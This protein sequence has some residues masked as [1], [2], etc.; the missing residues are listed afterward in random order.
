MVV[1]NVTQKELAIKVVYYGPPLSGKTTNLQKVYSFIRPQYRGKLMELD[2]KDDRTIFFDLLP[3]SFRTKKDYRINL[4]LF[5]VPGQVIHNATRRQ[6]LQQ[7]DG[8]VFVADAQKDRIRLNNS[9]WENMLENLESNGIDYH[10]VPV[11][12]QFN[13]IDLPDRLEDSK[14]EQFM[15]NSDRPVIKAS[16]INGEGVLETLR[17]LLVILWNN[18]DVRFR[19]VEKTGLST[20]EFIEAIFSF[21]KNEEPELR[22]TTEIKIEDRL[23][24]ELFHFDDTLLYELQESFTE[25]F[26]LPLSFYSYTNK[27]L[28]TRVPERIS[29]HK[30]RIAKLHGE[31]IR[32]KR[33]EQ[34]VLKEKKLVFLPLKGN[35]ATCISGVLFQ[36]EPIMK[37]VIGPYSLIDQKVP[38]PHYDEKRVKK[39]ANCISTVAT[40]LIYADY[41]VKVMTEQHVKTLKETF[42]E[43]KKKH[44]ELE[45]A[46]SKLKEVDRLKT[47]F[48][49]KVSHEL[50]TPLTSIKGYL[51]FIREDLKDASDDVKKY[52]DIVENK[53]DELYSLITNLLEATQFEDRAISLSKREVNLIPVIESCIQTILPMAK[54]KDIE[55]ITK[56]QDSIPQTLGDELKL[57]QVFV[58]ILNNAV[59]FSPE[60]S[61]IE[62]GIET[63]KNIII[64]EKRDIRRRKFG[65]EG[66]DYIVI[67]IR[68]Y[69]TGI[70]IDNLDKI[71]ELFYQ[72]E[73]THTRKHGGAGLGL[74]IAKKIIDAHE[75]TIKVESKK[76]QGSTF[77]IYLPIPPEE[78]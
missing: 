1:L 6:V 59:K 62:V 72:V 69:G 31:L 13:K 12:I 29:Q 15:R 44:T 38:F 52:L 40:E 5:T 20:D 37:L 17:T 35:L 23:K 16:A 25:A 45:E 78:Y 41:K 36:E 63:Q 57:K 73:E 48:L 24:E 22:I 46:Y 26:L 7:V 28:I 3:I 9:A 43:L 51:E 50:R 8:I 58:N 34:S 74:Y 55:I 56:I 2:T 4:K 21:I 42:E 19:I 27:N 65:T 64:D 30:S 47:T 11:V 32:H 76:N 61:R 49:A 10:S 75:G 54:K 66:R 71:F 70:D 14:I 67:W 53:T 18:L 68:D 60:K 39:I 33:A 77:Y